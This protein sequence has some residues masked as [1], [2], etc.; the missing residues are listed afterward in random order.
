MVVHNATACQPSTYNVEIHKRTPQ[1]L[2]ALPLRY[3]I[4]DFQRRYVWEEEEQWAPLWSDV[5]ALAQST[6]DGHQGNDAHFM[7]AI[8]LQQMENATGT[9]Q[10]RIVV[11]GQQRLT[12]LQL[13]INAIQ[14]LLKQ[15]GHSD[16]ATRL[17]ALV[18]NSGG[19]FSGNRDHAF[20]VWPTIVDR[21]AFKHA[22]SKQST[23]DH[24]DSRIVRAHR[25]FQSQ[26]DQWLGMLSVDSGERP[27]AADALE[28]AV[29]RRLLI[30]V[31]DLGDKDDPHVIFETL[32]ARGTPLL[33]SDM[34]KNK[35]LYDAK[36]E[37]SE[38]GSEASA[39]QKIWPFDQDWWAADVGRGLQRR[40]RIDVYLNHWLTLRNHTE[41][42]PYNEFNVFN[43]YAKRKGTPVETIAAD[44]DRVGQIYRDVEQEGRRT[45]IARFLERRKVMNVGVITPLLLWLLEAKLSA[46]KLANC[47]RALESFLVRRVVCGL[48][49][50]SL[51]EL[52]VGLIQKLDEDATG[53]KDQVLVSYLAEPARQQS[54]AALWPTNELL[55]ERLVREPLYLYLTRGRLRMV[56]EA[57]EE[58]LRTNKAES[59]EVPRGLHIEHIMPQK[60][61]DN[62]PLVGEVNEEAKAD[63]D[64][65]IHT[66]GN[67]TL[68]NG[69]LNAALSNAPWDRKRETLDAHSVLHLNRRLVK[70]GPE[71][72]DEVAIEQRARWLHKQAV[73][74]WPQSG[75][76]NVD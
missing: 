70:K 30:V 50:R 51:G 15:Q 34:V 54:Q 25:Y 68:V 20:K 60:W 65:A 41:T 11:D 57:I 74:V 47:I 42:K 7:G 37:I 46:V 9:I 62:Y 52:F 66:I 4:P 32:N 23:T 33:Q 8:V 13:L 72:W 28:A 61:H 40:P 27:K 35:I 31:I 12:T 75:D 16:P 14:G 49:A 26:A 76:F 55:Q 19:H 18:A 38:D 2:F 44:L 17:G 6:L 56:L 39:G 53:R 71:V 63:R 10:R 58:E 5:E 21:T 1:E 36:I 22:M 67:L 45:D 69:Q 3:E 29:S 48:S 24:A 73:K 59:K 64:R 43:T